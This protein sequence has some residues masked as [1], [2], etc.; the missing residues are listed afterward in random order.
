M[1]IYY[2]QTRGGVLQVMF[3]PQEFTD[4]PFKTAHFRRWCGPRWGVVFTFEKNERGFFL[5]VSLDPAKKRKDASFYISEPNSSEGRDVLWTLAH[6][7]GAHLLFDNIEIVPGRS[8]RLFNGVGFQ[9]RQDSDVYDGV[10][11]TFTDESEFDRANRQVDLEEVRELM[12]GLVMQSVLGPPVAPRIQLFFGDP[13]ERECSLCFELVASTELKEI[14]PWRFAC[15]SCQR[16]L[17]FLEGEGISPDEV[18]K[19]G[20]LTCGTCGEDLTESDPGFWICMACYK[21][22]I[23]EK[24]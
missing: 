7:T 12:P 5:L 18:V 23:N 9:L 10:W 3:D 15:E 22:K 16:D 2:E 11:H 17:E 1:F 6:F 21:R 19:I 13:D 14:R 20:N 8:L 4:E 24:K